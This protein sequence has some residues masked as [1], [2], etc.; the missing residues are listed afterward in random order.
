MTKGKIIF[1][2]DVDLD[3]INKVMI[4]D[5]EFVEVKHG[6][7]L[8][9]DDLYE[10]GICSVCGKDSTESWEYA[11]AEFNYCPHCGAKMIEVEE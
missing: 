11:K 10:S 6:R 9:S 4:R 3:G 1:Y 7:W 5:R 8:C 2:G